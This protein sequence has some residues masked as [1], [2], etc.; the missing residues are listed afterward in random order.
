MLT[1][2]STSRS[3]VLTSPLAPIVLTFTFILPGAAA[4]ALPPDVL[5]MAVSA[6]ED[7]RRGINY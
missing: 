4:S 1:V 3:Y 7:S 2:G 6:L 5:A